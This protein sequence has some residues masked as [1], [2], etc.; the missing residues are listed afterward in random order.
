MSANPLRPTKIFWGMGHLN[1]RLMCAIDIAVSG[2]NPEEDTILEIAVLPLSHMLK[3]HSKILMFNLRM[4]PEG[5]KEL[6]ASK[7]GIPQETL[8]QII[9]KGMDRYDAADHFINWVARN[10]IR[11][12]VP[13]SFNWNRDSDYLKR[14]IGYNEFNRIFDWRYRDVLSM[15]NFMNDRADSCREEIPHAKVDFAYLASLYKVEQFANRT[16]VN[17]VA[18]LAQLYKQMILNPRIEMP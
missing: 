7:L 2:E 11:Q 13:L 18:V 17:N 15:S 10:D 12:I 8:V 4:K 9:L 16:C 3:P 1:E 5:D 14:W 6:K